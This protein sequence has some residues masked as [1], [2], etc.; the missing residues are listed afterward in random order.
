MPKVSES[1]RSY[2]CI[3][4]VNGKGYMGEGKGLI[5]IAGRPMIEYV[6]DVIPDQVDEILISLEGEVYLD[7]YQEIAEKYL[8]SVTVDKSAGSSE[9]LRIRNAVSSATGTNVL[10]LPCEM[11]CLTIEFT[12]FLLEASRKFTAVIPRM[13]DGSANFTLAS[14]QSKPIVEAVEEARRRDP[15]IDMN[16]VIRYVKNVLYL[17]TNSLRFFD[18]KLT[19][20]YKVTSASD[21]PKVEHILKSRQ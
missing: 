5:K 6:L 8:A 15:N 10:L 13:S 18:S 20:L 16:S 19:F 9:L 21:I 2:S 12:Q 14:Y 4:L 3:V 17:S 1:E 11:P 7:R